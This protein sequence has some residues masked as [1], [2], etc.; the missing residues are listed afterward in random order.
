MA[1]FYSDNNKYMKAISEHTKQNSLSI[2]LMMLSFA[3]A[4]SGTKNSVITTTIIIFYQLIFILMYFC[5][6]RHY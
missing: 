4:L 5:F 6:Y 1:P 2:L 3:V